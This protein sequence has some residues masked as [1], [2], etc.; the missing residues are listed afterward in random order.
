[1]MI[2][3]NQSTKNNLFPDIDNTFF[4]NKIEALDNVGTNIVFTESFQNEIND[5]KN[6]LVYKR[7]RII[8]ITLQDA[9]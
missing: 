4:K 2:S 7:N 9:I 1:M 5:A 3:H 8:F 6:T